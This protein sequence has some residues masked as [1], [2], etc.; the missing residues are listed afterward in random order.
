MTFEKQRRDRSR[1]SYGRG[2]WIRTT[3]LMVPKQGLEKAEAACLLS[4][5]EYTL[6]PIECNCQYHLNDPY[7]IETMFLNNHLTP[8]PLDF[9]ELLK[10]R[11]FLQLPNRLQRRSSITRHNGYSGKHRRYW[12]LTKF[13]QWTKLHSHY[14]DKN[15][16]KE[17]AKCF[18]C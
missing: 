11:L 2:E 4:V 17:V 9:V 6:S 18:T 7:L 13:P 1:F 5:N 8:E 3:D 15:R 12:F 10:I 16:Q 14:C